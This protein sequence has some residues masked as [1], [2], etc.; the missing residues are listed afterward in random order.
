MSDETQD[1]D[2]TIQKKTAEQSLDAQQ[3]SVSTNNDTSNADN[4]STGDQ[5]VAHSDYQPSFRVKDEDGKL[6]LTGMYQNWFLDYASYV[7]L[8]RAVPHLD[9]GLKPVQR[10]ILHTMKLLDD[11]RYNKVANVVG[12]TMQ[13][14]PHGD[15]SIGDA[16]VQLGQKN[17]LIDTQGNW[18]N[19][20]TGDSAAAPRYIEARLSKFALDVLFNPQTTVWKMSYDGRKKEPVSLPVK[21]PLLLAQGAEGIAVGLA[22]KILPHN[23]GELCDAAISYLHGEEFHL[24]PDFQTGGSIDVSRYNDGMRGGQIKVRAKIE[25]LD[26]KTLV[27][28]EIPYGKTTS[29]LIDSILRANEKGKIK[30][31]KVE[32]NTAADV[33]ILVHL[34]PG[35]S[36]DKAIDALYA[37]TD[38][39]TSLNP[40]CCTIDEKKPKFLSVSDVLRRSVDSTRQLLEQELLIRRGELLESLHF[41]SLERIFIEERI[42]KDRAFEQ[43]KDMDAAVAH[44]DSR[45]APYKD[46]FYRE[47]TRDDI[48]RLMD[49][50]MGRI[51]KFNKDKAEE[52]IAR[53]NE[54]VARINRDLGNMVEVTANWF[55]LIRDKYAAQYPRRTEIRS[56]DNIEASKVIEAT[57]KLYIDRENGFMGTGLKKEE[58]VENCSPIDDVIIFY[59]DGTYKVTRVQDKVFI[60]ETER[61]KKERKKKV[62]IIHI[63]V[64]KRGDKRTIYNVVYRD[65]A[66]N[67][68][69][70]KR[71]N[72]TSILHDKEYDLTTGTPGSK[73]L[74]F[75]ANPNGEAEVI[76][77]TFRPNP[78]LKR[79]SM[80]KDFGEVL[81]KGRG[82]KGNLL[83]RLDV[84]RITLKAH[85]A[86]TL[87]GRKV[88]FDHDVQRL[89]YDA[90]GQ[91]LG[92]FHTDDAVLVVL[93]SGQFYTTNFD[94]N[95]HYEPTGI[96]RIEKFDAHKVW[97][98]VL[99]DAD[100]QNFPYVKRFNFERCTQARMQS[101]MGEN[102]R[103]QFVLLSDN[104]YP[105]LQITFGGADA[106]RDPMEVDVSTYIGVKSFKAKGKRLTTCTVDKIEELEP[107]RFPTSADEAE[108]NAADATESQASTEENE[109]LQR[110]T[111]F[112]EENNN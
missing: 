70:I 87:G 48:M 80:D 35:T 3:A 26:N 40:N 52:M 85:G 99:Y 42:Y 77:V 54:E 58:F 46:Q 25:K 8:E 103:S 19:I 79:I 110:S 64:F 105:R 50:K 2:K 44:I 11:G 84:H 101:F 82:S 111:L 88:W 53:M 102:P 104:V 12:Q 24:Y 74:Y 62:E 47:V 61:S 18:G 107:L 75:T 37:F 67:S 76:K 83:T 49:I 97:T 100:Q 56:F 55:R 89:N 33:E 93:E 66:T 21:F 59:R 38:C 7:I 43:A 15:A 109:T 1:K 95:N 39:E 27:I 96:M 41:A 6:Q 60:G 98:A 57:E 68:C 14:H 86:S 34:T 30:I 65:A 17:L 78:R 4:E 45:L 94:L 92:E 90:R 32:D 13:F 108:T 28:R 69:F 16:L 36:S 63:A 29:T 9:D 10:R 20:L 106:Y 51:L 112:D 22:A 31:R 71:F 73:V 91:Y 81:V 23:F 5:P 72:V